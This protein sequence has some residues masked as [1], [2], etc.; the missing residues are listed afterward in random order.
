MFIKTCMKTNC[1]SKHKI[2]TTKV[3]SLNPK[4]CHAYK[5]EQIA[6]VKVDGTKLVQSFNKSHVICF[7]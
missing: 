7:I 3:P 5:I 1:L 2:S 4:Q 6:T